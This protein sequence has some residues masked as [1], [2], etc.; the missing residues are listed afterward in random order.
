MRG[1]LWAFPQ[2]REGVHVNMGFE[3]ES[4]KYLGRLGISADPQEREWNDVGA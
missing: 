3:D 1:A 4:E 2:V